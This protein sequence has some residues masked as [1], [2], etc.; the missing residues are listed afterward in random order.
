MI[1]SKFT[2]IMTSEG[3]EGGKGGTVQPTLGTGMGCMA[4]GELQNIKTN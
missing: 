2:I 4:V 1:N 3:R